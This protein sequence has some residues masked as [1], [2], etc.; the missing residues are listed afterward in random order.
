MVNFG[1]KDDYAA[2]T[3]QTALPVTKEGGGF[4]AGAV[5]TPAPLPPPGDR[6]R[7]PNTGYALRG[8]NIFLANPFEDAPTGDNGFTGV[9]FKSVY[10]LFEDA[11]M[12]SDFRNRIPKGMKVFNKKICSFDF[13]ST[14][15][16]DEKEYLD[17]NVVSFKLLYY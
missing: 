9:I 17:N 7:M 5:T 13:E 1:W 14:V 2:T 8:Y 3:A 6:K 11:P 16:E 10:G 15:V 12:S 4:G